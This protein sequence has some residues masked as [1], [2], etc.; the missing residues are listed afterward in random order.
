MTS[1]ESRRLMRA[2]EGYARVVAAF[3]RVILEVTGC[4]PGEYSTWDEEADRVIEFVR[5]MRNPMSHMTQLL[6]HGELPAEMQRRLTN[7]H[8]ERFQNYRANWPRPDKEDK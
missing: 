3:Q 2:E 5:Y 1:D 8:A 7:P 4:S 6:P